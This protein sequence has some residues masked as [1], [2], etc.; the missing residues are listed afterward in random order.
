MEP[1]LGAGGRIVAAA[2]HQN[3][4]RA[5]KVARGERPAEQVEDGDFHGQRLQHAHE[6][7]DFVRSHRVAWIA[8]LEEEAAEGIGAGGHGAIGGFF[9]GGRGVP[10]GGD[11]D[12]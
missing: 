3:E 12:H 4:V 11:S 9:P 2:P 5:G 1:G 6:R 10:G 8:D 7:G